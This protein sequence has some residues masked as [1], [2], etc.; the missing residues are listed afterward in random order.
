MASRTSR[1]SVLTSASKPAPATGSG[2]YTPARPT[3]PR[4]TA[5]GSTVAPAASS[6]APDLRTPPPRGVRVE[7]QAP[8]KAPHKKNIFAALGEDDSDSD[9]AVSAPPAPTMAPVTTPTTPAPATI[10][11]PNPMEGFVRVKG[12]RDDDEDLGIKLSVGPTKTTPP[13]AK[14]TKSKAKS[15]AGV[16]ITAQVI[17][18][19][20]SYR[21][22]HGGADGRHGTGDRRGGGAP[23][24][25]ERK[26]WFLA[27]GIKKATT[28]PAP[29]PAPAADSAVLFPPMGTTTV[30]HAPS[31]SWAAGYE[32]HLE[33]LRNAERIAAK[34]A[35]QEREER[36]EAEYQAYLAEQEAARER[37][38]RNRITLTT[39]DWD[40]PD[41]DDDDDEGAYG[42]APAPDPD[43]WETYVS[44]HAAQAARR[45]YR[46]ELEAAAAKE[47][48]YF[49]D[50]HGN[51]VDADGN[52]IDEDELEGDDDPAWAAAQADRAARAGRAHDPDFEF[53]PHVAD[54]SIKDR[55]GNS[56]W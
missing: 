17:G 38:R 48:E 32:T 30:V 56:A 21:R 24:P 11:K 18:D 19:A 15:R 26:P 37:E 16:D 47:P 36:E 34:R 22:T 1:F 35:E 25:A 33:V 27:A 43:G 9:E 12:R 4:A 41:V 46:R 2:T 53:N 45:H 42:A 6:P 44:R 20:M 55:H 29:T 40:R 23:A 54:V 13:P 14:P 31:G 50:E 52:I 7:P 8:K 5:A 39:N 51:L 10:T 49:Y 3:R 28:A